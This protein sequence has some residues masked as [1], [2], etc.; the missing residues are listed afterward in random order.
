MMQRCLAFLILPVLLLMPLLAAC[1]GAVSGTETVRVAVLPIL[2]ALPMYV[3]EAQGYFGQEGIQVQFIPVSSAAE[4]DQ[5]MQSEQADAMINDLVSTMLY[6]KDQT[7]IQIVDFARTATA[8]FPQY[9]V[10]AAKDSGIET[11][12]DLKGVEIGVSEGTVIEYTTDRL[13]ENAGFAPSEIKTLAVPK[14]PDRMALLNSGELKAANL[15]D[16]LASLAIQQGA[17]VIV[18]DSSDPPIGNS[19]ISFRSAYILA[20]PNAVRGFLA[21]VQKAA[22]DVNADKSKWSDLL[23]EKSLVPAPLMGTYKIPDFPDGSVPTQ[24]Q[25]EDVLAWTHDKGL[26]ETDVSYADSVTAAYLPN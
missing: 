10:L 9:R 4:R 1:S 7:L 5:L 22:A 19:V 24:A 3:A 2:D 6:N 20:H 21:A 12:E 23:T 8:D 25:F 11:V 26:V 13:L 17:K 16:P 14:I 15:P 18:D